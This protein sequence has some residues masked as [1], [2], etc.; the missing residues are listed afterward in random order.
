MDEFS[1][2]FEGYGCFHAYPMIDGNFTHVLAVSGNHISG[3]TNADVHHLW[4]DDQLD[5]SLIPEG[6]ASIFPNLK[7]FAWYGAIR[8][9]SADDINFPD[10]LAIS[11]CKTRLETLDGDLFK[12]N[13]KL[14]IIGVIENPIKHIGIGLLDNLHKLSLADFEDNLCIDMIAE[15]PSAIDELKLKIKDQCGGE[16]KP[17]KNK[18]LFTAQLRLNFARRVAS[19]MTV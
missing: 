12:H 16:S 15:T 8:K 17:N 1:P 18:S 3:K 10:L 5:L 14:E 9:I 19:I 6:V 4:I 2:E 13:P 7:S 11:I